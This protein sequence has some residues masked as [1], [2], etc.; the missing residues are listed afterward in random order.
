M[1][2][3]DLNHYYG[4]DLE[5]AANGDLSLADPVTGGT[6]RVYRRLMTN[7]RYTNAAGQILASPDYLWHA[8]YGAGLPRRVGSPGNTQLLRAIIRGQMLMESA[9]ARS[10]APTITA[11]QTPDGTCT[12]NIKYTSAALVGD[13]Q[14]QFL[15]FS[16]T[17]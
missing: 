14:S 1:A 8:N 10:P 2:G 7:P 15:S 4:Q 6:Q 12:V 16:V 11:S 17:Q 3:L 13:P 5:V 9:V